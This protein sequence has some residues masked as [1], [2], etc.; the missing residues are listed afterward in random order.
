MGTPD[1]QWPE[2]TVGDWYD[3]THA[4]EATLDAFRLPATYL[5]RGQANSG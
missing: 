5:F 2:I 4:L 3:F 1:T